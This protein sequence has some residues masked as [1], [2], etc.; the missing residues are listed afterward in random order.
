MSGWLA[1]SYENDADFG[2]LS[3]IFLGGKSI[4]YIL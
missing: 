4:K 2:G 3:R 1:Q